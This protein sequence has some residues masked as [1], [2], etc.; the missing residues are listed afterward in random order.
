MKEK[1]T[2]PCRRQCYTSV[3]FHF[4]AQG[5]L[6]ALSTYI[7]LQLIEYYTSKSGEKMFKIL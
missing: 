4:H 6:Q 7:P 3:S 1:P 5:P 2:L